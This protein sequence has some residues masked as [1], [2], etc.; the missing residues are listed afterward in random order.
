[1]SKNDPYPYYDPCQPKSSDEMRDSVRERYLKWTFFSGGVS[2]LKTFSEFIFSDIL[3]NVYPTKEKGNIGYG[4]RARHKIN[5]GSRVFMYGPSGDTKIDDH[6]FGRVWSFREYFENYGFDDEQIQNQELRR[7]FDQEGLWRGYPAGYQ[8]KKRVRAD[9]DSYIV[10]S[11]VI[12]GHVEA[13]EKEGDRRVRVAL[14]QYR[15]LPVTYPKNKQ[16]VFCSNS[17]NDV[18][19]IGQVVESGESSMVIELL[20]ANLEVT[21][22]RILTKI[23]IDPTFVGNV[24]VATDALPSPDQVVS[25]TEGWYKDGT[26]LRNYL[27]ILRS[28]NEDVIKRRFCIRIVRAIGL[29][30]FSNEPAE[31]THAT[32]VVPF[33]GECFQIHPKIREEK[34]SPY[35]IVLRTTMMADTI[36]M[37]QAIAARDIREGEP[38]TWIYGDAYN[39]D[40][41]IGYPP[42]RTI[43]YK[44]QSTIKNKSK[45]RRT[46]NY[47]M[48]DKVLLQY[49]NGALI[50]QEGT[51]CFLTIDDIRN[52]GVDRT[53]RC[54]KHDHSISEFERLFGFDH[55]ITPYFKY[56]VSKNSKSDKL[57]TWQRKIEMNGDNTI[58]YDQFPYFRIQSGKIVTVRPFLK[59][60]FFQINWA[61]QGLSNSDTPNIIFEPIR[62]NIME[63]DGKNAV[64]SNEWIGKHNMTIS[65]FNCVGLIIVLNNGRNLRI[66]KVKSKDDGNVIVTTKSDTMKSGPARIMLPRTAR[67][68]KKG[69]E[70]TV[71]LKRKKKK[72]MSITRMSQLIKIYNDLIE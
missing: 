56:P 24:N 64:L 63:V 25:K 62:V 57:Y 66:E 34:L 29:Y 50:V 49:E 9:K 23:I 35:P 59:D 53:G 17:N 39:R 40:Y 11:V 47:W 13:L 15:A 10:T 27:T 14:G 48:G 72:K 41:S 45:K 20:R 31:N 30:A 26:P 68:I 12:H 67:Q 55:G 4:L 43:I 16:I 21:G 70:L 38:L 54:Q 58:F 36:Y 1:M 44:T 18:F 19:P 2:T 33:I 51:N 37:P 32:M 5:A 69:E 46:T 22:C 6:Y 42:R 7:L 61:I 60:E 52:P 28:Q 71:N 65:I 3:G 8:E